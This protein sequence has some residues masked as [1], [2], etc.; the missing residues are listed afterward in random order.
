MK[1]KVQGICRSLR[2]PRSFSDALVAANSRLLSKRFTKQEN[3]INDNRIYQQ[4]KDDY[5]LNYNGKNSYFI[6]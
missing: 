3:K 2:V 1:F 4:N 5:I 6:I